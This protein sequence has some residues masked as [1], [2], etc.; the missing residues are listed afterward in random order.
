M[1]TIS[2]IIPL[3]C[4]NA[5]FS[6]LHLLLLQAEGGLPAL[7]VYKGGQLIGNFVRVSDQLGDDFFAMDVESFLQE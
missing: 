6:S 5:L 2:N 3:T 4:V 1:G 7:L